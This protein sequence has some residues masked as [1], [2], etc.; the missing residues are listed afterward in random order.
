MLDNLFLTIGGSIVIVLLGLIAMVAKW[1]R[2]TS[3]GQALVKT[4]VGGTKVS[5]NGILI[6]PVLHKLELM[7]ISLKKYHHRKKWK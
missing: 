6:V 4:G 3:Q 1:Y 2:K 5:F 7:D